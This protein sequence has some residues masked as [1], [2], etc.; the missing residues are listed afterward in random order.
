[1]I[2]ESMVDK[3]LNRLSGRFPHAVVVNPPASALLLSQLEEAV[4][5]LPRELTIF[6]STCDGLHVR[7]GSGQG[8]RLWSVPEMLAQLRESPPPVNMVPV[9][10]ERDGAMDWVVTD[11]GPA[12]CAVVRWEPTAPGASLLATS[13]GR[14]LGAWVAHVIEHGDQRA[15]RSAPVF[16]ARWA[17]RHDPELAS[18]SECAEVRK[19]VR[20]LDCAVASGEDFE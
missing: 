12:H 13:F 15:A 9:R 11:G 17:R 18:V 14:Y 8:E 5:P 4:G 19:F 1:M 20:E 2:R 16:D 10:G 6:L 7:C 3:C